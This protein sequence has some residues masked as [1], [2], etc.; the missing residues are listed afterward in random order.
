LGLLTVDFDKAL[1]EALDQNFRNVTFSK[2]WFEDNGL[3]AEEK[4]IND[5]EAM[6]YEEECWR[7]GIDP[8]FDDDWP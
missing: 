3:N 5:R 2:G 4:A 7:F 8:G 6:E 1:Q